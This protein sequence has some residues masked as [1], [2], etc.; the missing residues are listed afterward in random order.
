MEALMYRNSNLICPYL[1]GGNDGAKCDV[2]DKLVRNIE[3]ADIQFCMNKHFEACTIYV[4]TLREMAL[5]A[6][7]ASAALRQD[8]NL[9][10]DATEAL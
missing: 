6:V 8:L 2:E 3:N 1:R 4:L 10:H 9:S 5:K 7:E